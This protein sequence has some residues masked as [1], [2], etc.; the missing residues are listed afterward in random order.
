MTT[1]NIFLNFSYKKIKICTI[2]E[3]QVPTIRIISDKKASAFKY[4]KMYSCWHL[5]KLQFNDD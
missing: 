3:N 2:F 1:S 5:H 4:I